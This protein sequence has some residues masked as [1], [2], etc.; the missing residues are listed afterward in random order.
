MKTH[1]G[2]CTVLRPARWALLCVIPVILAVACNRE[3][4]ISATSFEVHDAWVRADPDSGTTTAA[5]LRLVN[6]TRDTLVVS[7]FASDVARST[8][9]HETSIDAAGQA[10]MAMRDSLVIAPSHA[11]GMHPGAYHLMLVGTTQ[12]ILAGT[13]VRITMHLSDGSIVSTS[14]RVRQ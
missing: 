13:M 3:P 6:G 14:A 12:P 9:L 5:Y 7:R 1:I 2:Q 11:V 4:A 8:Q 10:R